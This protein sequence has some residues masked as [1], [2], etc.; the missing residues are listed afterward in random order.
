MEDQGRGWMET[1]PFPTLQVEIPSGNLIPL[2]RDIRAP[3]HKIDKFRRTVSPPRKR[4]YPCPSIL[5]LMRDLKR[6]LSCSLACFLIYSKN[7][8]V[9]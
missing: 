2:R 1:E 7:A 3:A 4:I 8:G 5:L 6:L 9:I